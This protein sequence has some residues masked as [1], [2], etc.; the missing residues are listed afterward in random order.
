MG[1]KSKVQKQRENALNKAREQQAII[2]QKKKA[3][4]RD[5]SEEKPPAAAPEC[6]APPA[7][8]HELEAK[9]TPRS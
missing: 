9:A 2:R 1:R 7:L 6:A 4:L 5:D 8:Q 3:A